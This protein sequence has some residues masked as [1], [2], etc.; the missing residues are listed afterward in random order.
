MLQL[1]KPWTR[2]PQLAAKLAANYSDAVLAWLP[3]APLSDGGN[4]YT[5]IWTQQ[6]A[7]AIDASASGV[8]RYSSSYTTNNRLT[9]VTAN[10]ATESWP[11]VTVVA[12]ITARA[13]SSGQF[14][15]IAAW[16]PVGELFGGF[17]LSLERDGNAPTPT[18]IYWR[19]GNSTTQLTPTTYGT[20]PASDQYSTGDAITIVA[21]WDG[22]TIW[23]VVNRNGV[24]TS[25]SNAHA[26]GWRN[27][28]SLFSLLGYERPA[29]SYRTTPH[30][31]HGVVVLPRSLRSGAE[32][33][34][35]NPWQLFAPR[36]IWVP[37]SVS[38]GGGTDLT[39]QEATHA[40]TA[41]GVTVTLSTTLT[42]A[43]ATHAHTA[44]A[45]ALTLDTVL[46]V[47]DATHA[48]TADNLTISASGAVN[49]TVDDATHA[50]TADSPTLTLGYVDLV[51][52]E[53]LHGHLADSPTLSVVEYTDLIIAE[54]LHAHTVDNLTLTFP[55]GA[56]SDAEFREMYDWVKELHRI[57]GL[58][59]GVDLV[60]TPTSRTAGAISQTISEVGTTVTVT[61]P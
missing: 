58:T 33:I 6:G 13:I 28:S 50:H 34:A 15:S 25:T 4:R 42:T 47:A 3:Q 14:P 21:G 51:I 7:L 56:L 29:A 37:V 54:A 31:V 60:V 26:P 22:A 35:R 18:M 24:I 12:C 2:Q 39:I 52:A 5:K 49:L 9:G 59:S 38:A 46:A 1:C 43:D 36:S 61:R 41:D 27:A 8:G 45:L 32:E 16:M 20:V 19:A 11:G 23:M 17:N 57:H 40:H 44:D 10:P 48:H 55:L 30:L 53:A